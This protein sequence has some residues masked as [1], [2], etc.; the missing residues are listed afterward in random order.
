MAGDQQKTLR[1]LRQ[2]NTGIAGDHRRHP[3][4][5][6]SGGENNAI[7]I[8]GVD[9]GGV[10]R[11]ERVVDLHAHDL[12]LG[13]MQRRRIADLART[14]LQRRHLAD[15]LAAL[16]GILFRKQ[17]LG[18]D[19]DEFRIAVI[20]IAIGVGQLHDF[21]QRMQILG[22]IIFHGPHVVTFE[23]VQSFQH[24]RPLGPEA[25]LVHLVAAIR[26]RNRILRL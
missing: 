8:H 13:G 14:E 9:A 23:H 10:A 25:G 17:P 26:G 6:R 22:G 3:G 21:S 16:G 1:S 4:P 15:Q 18:G 5:G 20:R 24:G 11:H 12:R 2:G 19:L 7:L